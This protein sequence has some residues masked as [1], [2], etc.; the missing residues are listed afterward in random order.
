MSQETSVKAEVKEE[1]SQQCAADECEDAVMEEPT[2][3]GYSQRETLPPGIKD[4]LLL[5][6][7]YGLLYTTVIQNRAHSHIH[8]CG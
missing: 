8:A 5:L 3:H 7:A 2:D 4:E 6:S 1:V